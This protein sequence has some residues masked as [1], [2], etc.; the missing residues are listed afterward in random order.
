MYYS[1]SYLSD[2]LQIILYPW[3]HIV[4][5]PFGNWEL[6]AFSQ[7][8]NKWINKEFRNS[9]PCA[10]TTNSVKKFLPL[11]RHS[12]MLYFAVELLGLVTCE[13]LSYSAS[14]T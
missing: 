5:L 10:H 3:Q 8:P 9:D 14:V 2:Y 12:G 6:S 1:N 4:H 11:C 13:F 7:L